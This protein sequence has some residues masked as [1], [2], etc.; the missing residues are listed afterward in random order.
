MDPETGLPINGI[1]QNGSDSG[2]DRNFLTNYDYI[3]NTHMRVGK[4]YYFAVTAYTYNSDPQAN[5]NNSESLLEVIE[6]V[7]Y[8]SL[9]GAVYGDSII[10]THSQ[11]IGDGNVYVVVDDP[12]QLTG[13]DYQVSFQPTAIL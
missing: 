5:P 13:D 9:G 2:I 1:Q 8:D 11:G 7:F 4:K 10:V 12:T 3:E 6:A